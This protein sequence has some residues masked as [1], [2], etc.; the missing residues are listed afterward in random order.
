MLKT[1]SIKKLVIGGAAVLALTA[2]LATASALVPSTANAQATVG[3]QNGPGDGTGRQ[4]RGEHGT[5]LAEAL[6]I[7]VEELETAVESVRQTRLGQADNMGE[8]PGVGR[9]ARGFGRHARGEGH[10]LL[11]DALGISV[12]QLEGA[13]NTVRENAVAAAVAEGRITPEQA[14]EMAARHAV[15]GYMDRDEVLASVLG[16]TADQLADARE[17]GTSLR[18]LIAE[19][20]MD[21]AALHEAMMAAHEAAV[22]QAVA[23]GVITQ[24]QADDLEFGEGNGFGGHG[25]GRHG[26]NRGGPRSNGGEG[27]LNDGSSNFRGGAG[28]FAPQGTL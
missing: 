17:S 15:R 23:D 11:A 26:G 22:A 6:G 3:F 21:R 14:D 10:E 28:R 2:A 13:V 9:H 18:D 25:H 1:R 5:E 27:P 4:A 8:R 12:E 24:E 7:S 20:G 19:S 16:L